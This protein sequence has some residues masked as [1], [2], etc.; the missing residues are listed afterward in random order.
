MLLAIS[1]I[2]RVLVVLVVWDMIVG[3][4]SN[5]SVIFIMV[6]FVAVVVPWTVVVW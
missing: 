2:M 1:A 3:E 5:A 4:R 6:V